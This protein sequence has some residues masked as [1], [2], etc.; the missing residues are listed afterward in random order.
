IQEV[1]ADLHPYRML[2]AHHVS[3]WRFARATTT[4]GAR[5]AL[6]LVLAGLAGRCAAAVVRR[7]L[8]GRVPPAGV[9]ESRPL[10]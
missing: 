7:R 1:S 5:L 2:A 3:M 9:A 6:P 8:A 4:G 10:A